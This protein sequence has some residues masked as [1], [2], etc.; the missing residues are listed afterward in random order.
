MRE[1]PIAA[2]RERK[3]KEEAVAVAWRL[4]GMLETL[5]GG[6]GVLA[7]FLGGGGGFW[8][9]FWGMVYGMG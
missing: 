3:R 9:C 7:F 1:T 6:G 4:G 8:F 2:P 5:G